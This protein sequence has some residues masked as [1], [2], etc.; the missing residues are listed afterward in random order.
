MTG[1]GVRAPFVRRLLADALGR[2]VRRVAVRSA[3]AV[4]AAMLAARGVGEPVEPRVVTDDPVEPGPGR[5]AAVAR[6]ERWRGTTR[7]LA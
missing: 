1:G 3:T 5:A 2:P 6:L 4:G 7:R